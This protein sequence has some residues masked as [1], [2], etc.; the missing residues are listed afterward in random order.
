M[1]RVPLAAAFTGLLPVVL[2]LADDPTE[3][4]LSVPRA[5]IKIIVGRDVSRVVGPGWQ[6]V[7]EAGA[8]ALDFEVSPGRRMML[9]REGDRWVGEYVHPRV[10]PGDH[11]FE[12]HI[13]AFD[14]KRNGTP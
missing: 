7:F 10:R 8:K 4:W 6:H 2:P 14:K 12:T 13:M 3:T 11:E 9:R 1:R 5:E